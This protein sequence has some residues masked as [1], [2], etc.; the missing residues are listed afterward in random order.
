VR[1]ALEPWI[2][3]LA[4]LGLRDRVALAFALTGL[5][6]SVVFA[7]AASVVV[8]QYLNHQSE[9]EALAEAVD[10]AALIKT[11]V[12]TLKQDPG[13]IMTE[14]QFP[15]GGGAVLLFRG[16][17]YLSP[18]TAHVPVPSD[19]LLGE[20]AGR[21]V[22]RR[23][24]V[25][26]RDRL[27]VAVPFN[28]RARNALIEMF[29]LTDLQTTL[30]TLWV[31]LLVSAACTSLLGLAIGRIASRRLV[32]P[33]TE[34]TAAAAAIAGGDL[35]ARLKVPREPD[36]ASLAGSFNRTAERL[37]SRVRADARFAGDV[38]H[39]LRT[40][41]TTMLNS[42]A[43]LQNRRHALPA[44]L[45][46]PLGLLEEDLMSFRKLVLDLL[47]ISR[48][49]GGR[50]TDL[51]WVTIPDLVRRAADA[52]AGRPVT[53]ID[54]EA[55]GLRLQVDKRLLE[56]VLVN[57]VE[58][59]ETHGRGCREV[60][61]AVP[62]GVTRIAVVDSGPGVPADQKERVFDRFVR[63]D[64]T[65]RPGAGLGLAI[66]ERHVIRLGGEV[67][68]EDEPGGGARFVVDL[69]SQSR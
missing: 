43:L 18:A 35:S 46:E 56:Q 69:P 63:F 20:S 44:E 15:D 14:L 51:E 37:E 41:L 62:D 39:E 58:N 34:V 45:E 55:D 54:P 22:V 28:D 19:L 31:I 49:D 23:V 32:R 9:R 57:L 2:N 24:S 42:L 66:V 4:G 25:E 33:L 40:P 59:A 64:T 10:N 27:L 60:S 26:D 47:E 29:P 6:L 50:S 3:R 5:L 52:T 48:A 12:V 61:V 17:P 1:P 7:L 21:T 67:R 13:T 53:L 68:V 38:S 11:K 65:G 16:D 30:R 36:L 8:T